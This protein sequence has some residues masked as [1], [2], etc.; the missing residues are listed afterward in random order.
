MADVVKFAG[1]ELTAQE[2]STITIAAL[3]EGARTTHWK[4]RIQKKLLDR[5]M[6]SMRVSLVSGESIDQAITAVVGGTI[7]TGLVESSK[8][9]T[10][11]LI[12]TAVLAVANQSR[13]LTFQK[14]A[15]IVKWVQQVSILD[16]KTSDICV[17]YSGQAWDLNTLL[18]VPPAFL[19]FK[20]GPPRHFN[21][22]ST[23][24]PILRSWEEL[25]IAAASLTE[26]QK[27]ALDGKL[28][29]EIS[30]DQWLRKKTSSFQ[31]K[32]L[33]PAR[34]RLWRNGT[35]TLTQLVDMRGNP[36]TLE[37]LDKKI[38]SRRKR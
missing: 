9:L 28:P 17:A 11:S 1:K 19:P 14:N 29:K 24:I 5:V 7:G 33:G 25:G 2:A 36:L 21:C 23:L 35:I 13:L 20:G 6:D 37:Q 22:R 34:A 26:A 12:N 10:A 4:N 15:D 8:K 38:K 27:K 3:I 30:F 16:N 18:P 32:L 31:D